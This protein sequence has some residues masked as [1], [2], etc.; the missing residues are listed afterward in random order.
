MILDHPIIRRIEKYGYDYEPFNLEEVAE[1]EMIDLP[2][3]EKLE[4]QK[5]MS[6]AGGYWVFDGDVPMM[7]FETRAK[8]EKYIAMR[9]EMEN[10]KSVG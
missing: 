4:D 1:N 7:R 2:F 8:Y 10:K 3:S 5:A 9:K 6:W